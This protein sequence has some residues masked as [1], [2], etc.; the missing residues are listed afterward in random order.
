MPRVPKPYIRS[1]SRNYTLIRGIERYSKARTYSKSGDWAKRPNK[2]KK[3]E[4]PKP[5]AEKKI[6]KFQGG[7]RE[8]QKKHPRGVSEKK[9]PR[10]CL[11]VHHRPTRL[12]KS[13]IPGT[14]LIL[15]SGPYRGR[16]VVFLKQLKK[17]GLLLVN[18]PFCVNRVPIR[19]VNQAYVIA[20]S[21]HVPI[22]FKL[23]ANLDDN[24][25]KKPKPAKKPKAQDDAFAPENK[26]QP[27]PA[28]KKELQ[29]KVDALLLPIIKKTPLLKQYLRARFSL[30]KAHYPHLL[31]F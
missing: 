12:R 8:I 5:K 14:V 28:E 6:V 11:K 16:R 7:T 18:G 17:S 15:L 3:V 1:S 30:N 31:K 2:W 20:T 21:T 4:T 29:K 26:K 9:A 25:F 23:P 27:F 22:T 24:Y 13:I 19:R 10:R